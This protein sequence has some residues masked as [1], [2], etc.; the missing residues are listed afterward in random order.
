MPL[1]HILILRTVLCHPYMASGWISAHSTMCIPLLCGSMWYWESLVQHRRGG[2]KYCV[3]LQCSTLYWNIWSIY[4]KWLNF[5]P[6]CNVYPIAVWFNVVLRELSPTQKRRR[7]ILRPLTM[8]HT[9]LEYLIHIWQV[10]EFL[11][12]LQ[13]VSHCCVVQCGTERA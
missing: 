11:P 10:V 9:L 7:E 1:S 2:G 3:R 4:G 13:C 5:C 12:T 8:F 6:L